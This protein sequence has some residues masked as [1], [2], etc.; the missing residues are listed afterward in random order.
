MT[1]LVTVTGATLPTPFRM[2]MLPH[3]SA[4]GKKTANHTLAIAAALPAQP[5][6]AMAIPDKEYP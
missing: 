6:F 5:L 1:S 2:I 4:T 3:L